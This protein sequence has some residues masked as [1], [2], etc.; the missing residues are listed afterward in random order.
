M[1]SKALPIPGVRIGHSSDF[2]GLTGCTVLL[3][4]DG[5]VAGM[6]VRGTASGSRQLDSLNPLHLVTKVQ[7]LLLCGG[8][9][10]GLRATDGV[11]RYLEER[12]KGFDVTVGVVPIVPTAILFDLAVGD[13]SA[14]PTVD[15]GYEACVR[16]RPDRIPEGSV[17]VGTGATV[18]KILGFERAMKGGFGLSSLTHPSGFSV[19][20][21]AA[22][23]AFGDVKDYRTGEL[24]AGT[25]ASPRGRKL[26]PSARVLQQG[27][28]PAPAL[29]QNTTLAAVVTDVMLTKVQ[30]TKVA[31]MAMSGIIKTTSPSLTVY[32]G[33]ILFALSYGDKTSDLN[34]VG[35]LAEVAVGEAVGRA[36]RLAKGVRGI[37][38]FRDLK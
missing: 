30:A 6:D 27:L 13:W 14:R 1:K 12:G 33:D 35:Y 22:V 36:V 21:A 3:C 5:A 25:R 26:Y 16:A 7:A 23:N 32:D 37:P 31:Q 20:A 17:G 24:L 38:A 18:G 2:R 11:L 19:V 15:M 4:E 9:I 28:K 29:F 8:S 34:Q 10:Y